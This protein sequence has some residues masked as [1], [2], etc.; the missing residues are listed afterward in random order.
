M[1][2]AAGGVCSSVFAELMRNPNIDPVPIC[3]TQGCESDAG[4]SEI[5]RFIP[6]TCPN[7]I[8]AYMQNHGVSEVVLAGDVGVLRDAPDQFV[9]NGSGFDPDPEMLELLDSNSPI[10]SQLKVLEF[11]LKTA[12]ITTLHLHDVTQDFNVGTQWIGGAPLCK[13]RRQITVKIDQTVREMRLSGTIENSSRATLVFEDEKLLFSWPENTHRV[14]E[15]AGSTPRSKKGSIRSLVK[16]STDVNP[17]TLAAPTLCHEDIS[18]CIEHGI[19][20]VILDSDHIV[21]AEKKSAL[22]AALDRGITVFGMSFS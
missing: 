22:A 11:R 7:E 20:L 17:V 1:L 9:Q 8:A 3:V 4:T 21:F 6:L 19:D 18:H 5:L 2:L 13:A 10:Y 12:G 14:V 15:Y 16:L